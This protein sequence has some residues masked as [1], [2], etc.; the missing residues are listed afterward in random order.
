MAPK[1]A[2]WTRFCEGVSANLQDCFAQ[3]R[4]KAVEV[5]EKISTV[6]KKRWALVLSTFG[7]LCTFLG[8]LLAAA[9]MPSATKT[10][11]L[12]IWTAH[13]DFLGWCES[14]LVSRNHSP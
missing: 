3:L 6:S 2:V 5:K 11:A 13:K 14:E 9:L 1:S 12:A 8:M 4:N 10:E 7:A